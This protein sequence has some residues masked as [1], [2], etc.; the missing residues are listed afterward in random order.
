MWKLAYI[1]FLFVA[2]CWY[3]DVWEVSL[4]IHHHACAVN[5]YCLCNSTCEWS[6]LLH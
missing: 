4:L 3:L 6:K 1:V 5:L 2:V